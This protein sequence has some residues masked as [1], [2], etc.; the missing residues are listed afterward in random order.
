M[1]LYPLPE[2]KKYG[3]WAKMKKKIKHLR[4]N[5]ESFYNPSKYTQQFLNALG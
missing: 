2:K 1:L 4:I 3:A 5:T